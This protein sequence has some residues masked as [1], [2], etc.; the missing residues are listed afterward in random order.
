MKNGV[1]NLQLVK[2]D[3]TDSNK[4]LSGAKFKVTLADGTSREYVTNE[5]GEFSISDIQ[6]SETG[7][8]TITIEE[9]EAPAGYN[10]IIDTLKIEVTK[11]VD[12]SK[13]IVTDVKFSDDT[14]S[15]GSTVTLQ[16]STIIVT[17]PNEKVF[18]I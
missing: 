8:D 14:Q 3:S 11:G 1:Y 4:T 9:I 16:G 6:I 7:I 2:V 12:G 17:V 5:N 15:N 13:Y 18:S 10:K